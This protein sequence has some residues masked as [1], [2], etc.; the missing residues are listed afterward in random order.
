MDENF[1]DLQKLLRLKK[2]ETPSP[3]YFEGF[4][5]DFHR[6]QRQE[7]VKLPIWRIAWD[8]VTASFVP[9]E[10]PRFAYA[11]A[12]AAV[13]FVT[14][15]ASKQMV[16]RPAGSDLAVVT[17]AVSA[18][19]FESSPVSLSLNRKPQAFL[20]GAGFASARDSRSRVQG[21]LTSEQARS[22]RYV[23]DARPVS[24]EAPVSF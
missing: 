6:R 11:T 17:P 22:P 19:R 16:S 15:F 9:G 13:L 10:V 3:E 5:K 4:L 24:Y 1:S 21:G 18:S 12:C 20:N 8:R 23:L 14:V 2:Y 7:I